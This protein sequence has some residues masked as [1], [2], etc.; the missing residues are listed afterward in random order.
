MTRG[1]VPDDGRKRRL[2]VARCTQPGGR[3]RSQRAADAAEPGLL[4]PA[5]EEVYSEFNTLVEQTRARSKELEEENEL[6]LQQLHQVQEELEAT[7]QSQS[8][9]ERQTRCARERQQCFRSVQRQLTDLQTEFRSN[10]SDE[11]RKDLEEE[12]EL[13]LQQLHHVQEELESYYL[14]GMDAR[15]ELEEARTTIEALYNSMSWKIT[16]P[17]RFV[18]DLFTGHRGETR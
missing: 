10:Q 17:L 18:L 8:R 9:L 1:G 11:R 5:V 7:F 6:L 3:T 15:H 13:L 12:N 4:L 16:R 2:A 14:N